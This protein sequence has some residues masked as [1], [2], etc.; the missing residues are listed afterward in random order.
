MKRLLA[1]LAALALAGPA[2]A[3]DLGVAPIFKAQPTACI[4]TNCTGF[5]AGVNGT[6]EVSSLNVLGAGLSNAATL[7]DFG[8]HAG[9]EVWNG[10]WFAAA[11]VRVMGDVTG[12]GGSSNRLTTMELVKAG[13]SLSGLFSLG[14][15]SGAAPASITLPPDLASS[16]ITPYLIF[17]QEQVGKIGH[18]VGGFGAQLLVSKNNTVSIDYLNA[19]AVNNMPVVNSVM[20]SID[21]HF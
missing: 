21:H 10:K 18:A 20:L 2:Y 19:P 1:I 12:N 5:Y 17:G 8:V 13:Y 15:A 11:E 9:Y 4:Q 14:A 7:A 6:F 3:A 16:L